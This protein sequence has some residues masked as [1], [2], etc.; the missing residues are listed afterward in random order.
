MKKLLCRLL[1]HKCLFNF[2][3]MPS[4]C[5]CKRCKQ[6]FKMDYANIFSDWEEIKSF[7]GEYRSDEE[8]IKDWVN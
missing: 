5:I 8:L 2:K 6:K 3:S 7:G 4:K 1:G